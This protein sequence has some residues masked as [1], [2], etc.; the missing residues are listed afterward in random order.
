[1]TELDRWSLIYFGH[2]VF[3]NGINMPCSFKKDSLHFVE[4]HTFFD[5][6][7]LCG[8]PQSM[9][10]FGICVRGFASELKL[11][12]H[13]FVITEAEIMDLFRKIYEYYERFDC[14]LTISAM[15]EVFYDQV[16]TYF[17]RIGHYIHDTDVELS[18]LVATIRA[19]LQK[20]LKN[21]TKVA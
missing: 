3:K 5:R 11:L 19:E 13:P 6:Q 20:A 21:M 12:L 14:R 17:T 10:T 2:M 7:D 4:A 9:E 1:M 8:L 15:V 16:K 18:Q